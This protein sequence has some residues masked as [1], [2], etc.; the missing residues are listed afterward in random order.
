MVAYENHLVPRLYCLQDGSP[1][2]VEAVLTGGTATTAAALLLALPAYDAAVINEARVSQ[3]QLLGLA[4][5]LLGAGSEQLE[6]VQG[7]RADADAVRHSL[8][9]AAATC[10]CRPAEAQLLLR[11]RFGWLTDARARTLAAGTCGLA[12]MLQ[13]LGV[14]H[15][16]VSDADLLDGA[17]RELLAQDPQ[18][19]Q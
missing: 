6:A 3:G 17:M 16:R 12:A 18:L 1:G 9:G 11:Q 7:L 14:Q 15:A 4:L 13:L 10:T 2:P 19:T 8:L 5:A